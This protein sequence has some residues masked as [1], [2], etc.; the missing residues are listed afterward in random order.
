MGDD[1]EGIRY[2]INGIT[3]IMTIGLQGSGKTTAIGKLAV[4]IRK[5]EKKKVCSL[6]QTFIDQQPLNN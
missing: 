2:N 6:L 4:F 5:Q 1:A 3:T